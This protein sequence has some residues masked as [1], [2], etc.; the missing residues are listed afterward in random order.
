MSKGGIIHTIAFDFII[1]LNIPYWLSRSLVFKTSNTNVSIPST[2]W[3]LLEQNVALITW[4]CFGKDISQSSC[5]QYWGYTIPRASMTPWARKIICNSQINFFA[6]LAKAPIKITKLQ[7][8]TKWIEKKK[9]WKS[10]YNSWI[11]V[12]ITHALQ[13]TKLHK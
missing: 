2:N 12:F 10:C 11:K 13:N 9:W 1:N 8:K 5:D 7:N 4:R 3:V 6:N